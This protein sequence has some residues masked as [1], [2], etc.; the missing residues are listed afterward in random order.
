MTQNIIIGKN[1]SLTE[2]NFKN[3]KNCIVFSA[4]QMNEK[5]LY[6]KINRVKK[7]NL[8]FNNFF[9]QNFLMI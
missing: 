9:L 2:S 3:I 5:N 8:I 4:N 6:D 1:S 7:V